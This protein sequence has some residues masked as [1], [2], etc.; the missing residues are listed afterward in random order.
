MPLSDQDFIKKF[1]HSSVLFSIVHS[2]AAGF[3]RVVTIEQQLPGQKFFS[4][5]A[6]SYVL[7]GE[8]FVIFKNYDCSIQQSWLKL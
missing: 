4:T 3:L 5:I 7:R 8:S 6:I 1:V 2:C